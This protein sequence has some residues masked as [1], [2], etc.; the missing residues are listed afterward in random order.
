MANE[1]KGLLEK[2]EVH[3]PII[4]V[5]HSY[6]GLCAQHFIKMYPTL[7]NSC[8]LVDSTSVNLHRLNELELPVLD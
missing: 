4:L 3:D 6:G 2:L 7:V 5:G 8:I 1:L